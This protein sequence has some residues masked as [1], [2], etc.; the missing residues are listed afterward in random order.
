MNMKTFFDT[1]RPLYGPF[2]NETVLGME[3]LLTQGQKQGLSI[4]HMSHV[5]GHVRRETGG[6]MAPIKET[7]YASHKD[8][9]PSDAEVIRRLDKAYAA[10][11]LKWVK[12]PYW[13]N[14]AFGRGQIQLT[15]ADNY[16]KFGVK[17]FSDALKYDVSAMV[18]VVGMAKG[19]FTGKK[20]ADYNFPA[21]LDA[22]PSKNPRRIVNGVDGSDKEVA[23]STRVYHD[24]LVKAGWGDGIAIKPAPAPDTSTPSTDGWLVS[25]IKAIIAMFTGAK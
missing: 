22:A 5:L 17:P 16:A 25:L 23:A 21:A 10:G 3:H 11:Q 9:N 15:H 18:A 13:R 12:T 14:G 6:W 2:A 7:V 8:K 19:M 20:L 4:W 24:A 1:L